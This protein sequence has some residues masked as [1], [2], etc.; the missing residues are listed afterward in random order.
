[1]DFNN[2]Q[3]TPADLRHLL[4]DPTTKPFLQ[5]KLKE[6]H[7]IFK[8]DHPNLNL[9]HP[10]SFLQTPEI[11]FIL[12]AKALELKAMLNPEKIS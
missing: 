4:A 8:Q 10:E 9:A 7:A 11:A 12:S 3:I 2:Y 6:L 1:M 5:A